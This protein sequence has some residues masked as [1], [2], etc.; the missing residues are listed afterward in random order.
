MKLREIF[1][2]K[3][4]V[5]LIE[6]L[7]VMSLLGILAALGIPMI[8][9]TYLVSAEQTATHLVKTVVDTARWYSL[10]RYQNTQHGVYITST[11]M[12]SYQ[13]P[14]YT[15]RNVA[16]DVFTPVSGMVLESTFVGN[17]I[18][19][20]SGSGAVQQTGTI[21]IVYPDQREKK[22]MISEQGIIYEE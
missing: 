14:S 13:G 15:Q 3:R 19:F 6:L 17:D 10:S 11:G 20:I 8:T 1:N 2:D 22:L 12:I 7:L 21:M 5:S 16:Y 9:N 18:I 4:G